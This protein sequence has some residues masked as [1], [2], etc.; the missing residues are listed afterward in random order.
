MR[1]AQI[2]NGDFAIIL[3]ENCKV[4]P[5]EAKGVVIR[6]GVW[7]GQPPLDAVIPYVAIISIISCLPH[8]IKHPQHAGN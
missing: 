8:P 4:P 6:P 7:C 2:L 5:Q 1:C 3:G